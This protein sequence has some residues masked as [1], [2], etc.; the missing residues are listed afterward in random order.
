MPDATVPTPPPS[1]DLVP[2]RLVS[3]CPRPGREMQSPRGRARLRPSA[4]SLARQ[5][6]NCFVRGNRE[7][8]ER[9]V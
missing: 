8:S 2:L 3:C 6:V 1:P 7:L 4:A 5:H 9:A